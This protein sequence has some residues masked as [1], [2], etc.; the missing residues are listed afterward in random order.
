MTIIIGFFFLYALWLFYLAVMCLK[1]ARDAGRLTKWAKLFGY[2]I[3]IVG[4]LLDIIAN[5]V[6]LTVLLLEL[7]HEFVVTERLS[8]HI[9]FSGGFRYAIAKWFCTNLL[10]PYDPSGCHCK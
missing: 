5:V 3:L 2:P 10:D 7:P 9:K 1:G 6:I 4:Y 8:R